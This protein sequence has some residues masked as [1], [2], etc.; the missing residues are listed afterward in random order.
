MDHALY[1]YSAL[2]ARAPLRWPESRPVALWICLHLEYWELDPPADARHPAGI[3]GTWQIF[4]PDYRTFA[5]REYGNRIGFF[6][7]VEAIDRWRLPVTVAVN[8][9][10]C[11]R[12]PHLVR[13]C[14]ARGWEI[15][16]GGTHATRMITSD[17]PEPEERAC[18][19]AS[20]A[21]VREV[22]GVDPDGWIGQDFGESARTP[23]IVAE[24]G[25]RYIADWPN[26]EQP[27]WMATVPRLV[28]V[29]QQTEW[30]DVTLLWMRQVAT[31]RF[32]RMIDAAL[33]RLVR[34]GASAARTFVLNI[35][36]WL[37]G[38]PHRIRY[39]R[40]TLELVSRHEVWATTAREIAARFAVQAKEAAR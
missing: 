17:M 26:D 8:A 34:D 11:E 25:F 10:V 24:H 21:A 2:P 14:C 15:A 29:P 16:A 22:A 28:S 7:V 18:V 33:G 6:R 37:F 3:E 39:L 32:P 19:A 27:Y 1:G 20:K 38:Q 12:Y 30:D 5:H 40:E 23:Y 31:D 4:A 13:E 35:H 9:A 36:P